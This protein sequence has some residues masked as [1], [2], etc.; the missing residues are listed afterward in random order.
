MFGMGIM[1]TMKL[2]THMREAVRASADRNIPANTAVNR[3]TAA[4][5]L[6]AFAMLSKAKRAV[7]FYS[8]MSM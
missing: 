7:A 8:R 5:M 6:A 4:G 1:L 2:N 3:A